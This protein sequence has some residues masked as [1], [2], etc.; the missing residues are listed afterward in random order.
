MPKIS[1]KSLDDEKIT[2]LGKSTITAI[3]SG[4]FWGYVCMIEGLINK[5]KKYHSPFKVIAT[6]GL[7]QVFKNN[8]KSIDLIEQNLTINGLA[9]FY[10]SQ[11]KDI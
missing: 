1:L 9:Y 3:E 7:S 8:I 4:V 2:L 6:G 5:L 10:L 11:E